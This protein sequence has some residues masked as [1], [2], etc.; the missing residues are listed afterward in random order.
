M[1]SD[2]VRQLQAILIGNDAPTIKVPKNGRPAN[3]PAAGSIAQ[4]DYLKR[5]I[6]AA[7]F[8]GPGCRRGRA[9]AFVV[10]LSNELVLRCG[11][12]C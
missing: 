2:A 9:R 3:V 10:S 6:P 7:E 12:S 11:A 1:P 8:A 5:E 4:E